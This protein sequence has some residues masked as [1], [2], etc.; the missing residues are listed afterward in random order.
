MKMKNK[1]QENTLKTKNVTKEYKAY[2]KKIIVIL[3]AMFIATVVC[4][5]FAL[6]SG[7]A[8]MTLKNTFETLIETGLSG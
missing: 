7:V 8:E 2:Q 5:Y 1:T 4:M 6:R 3:I